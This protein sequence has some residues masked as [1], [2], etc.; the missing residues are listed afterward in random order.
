MHLS[1]SVVFA[2]LAPSVFDFSTGPFPIMAIEE[3]SSS[4]F[5]ADWLITHPKGA[6]GGGRNTIGQSVNWIRSLLISADTE[7]EFVGNDDDFKNNIVSR[8]LQCS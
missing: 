3:T 8:T 7:G 5:E 2:I 6:P 1:Q 4:K